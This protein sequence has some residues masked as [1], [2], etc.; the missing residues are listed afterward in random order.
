MEVSARAKQLRVA[1]RKVR[2]VLK[3]LPGKRVEDALNILRFMTTPS[4]RDVAKV[5]KSAAANA[6]N[7]FQID[8]DALRIKAA[9]ADEAPRYKRMRPRARGRGTKIVH[10]TSHITVIVEEEAQRGT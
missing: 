1:P 6:E 2:L 3:T 7:N 10:R 9:W 8:P 5:V 4:A